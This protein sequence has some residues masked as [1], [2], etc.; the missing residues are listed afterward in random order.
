MENVQLTWTPLS[1]LK[2]ES[3]ELLPNAAAG[4]YRLS[5][6]ESSED[7]F[8]VFYVFDTLN[9]K[10]SL[11]AHLNESTNSCISVKINN[12]E[13]AFRF[14]QIS[15]EIVRKAA[16]KQ[17]YFHYQPMCNEKVPEGNNDDILVNLT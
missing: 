7:D 14:A 17:A 6:R 13:C 8:Y 15:D 1:P 4:V 5:Y 16:V 12:K 3:I 10:E 2:K 11:L 9:I